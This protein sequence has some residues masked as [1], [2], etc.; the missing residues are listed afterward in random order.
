VIGRI[1]T[2]RLDLAANTLFVA[3]SVGAPDDIPL[4][5]AEQR[6]S[7]CI[8]FS[9]LPPGPH[10]L[11]T[12]YQCQPDA[13]VQAAL[14]RARRDDPST[15]SGRLDAIAQAVKARTRPR[16]VSLRYGR[17]GYGLLRCDT[18][19]A[20]LTGADNGSEIGAL[21]QLFHAQRL[22]NL[23]VRFREYLRFGLEAGV[24]F[25]DE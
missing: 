12:T 4:L 8:R 7:G 2:E 10:R 13:A 20:L 14:A 22:A 17:P 18:D 25:E 23:Q 1:Y 24:F 9:H 5:Y 3:S 15:P 11:P 6:Q 16:F 21:N 19:Q